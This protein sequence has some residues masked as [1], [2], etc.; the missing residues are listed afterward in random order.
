[1]RKCFASKEHKRTHSGGAATKSERGRPRPRVLRQE[2]NTRTRASALRWQE[3]F[4][5]SLQTILVQSVERPNASCLLHEIIPSSG[6]RPNCDAYLRAS[7]S[8]ATRRGRNRFV[9]FS[10]FAGVVSRRRRTADCLARAGAIVPLH[11][12]MEHSF[13]PHRAP[14]GLIEPL[15]NLNCLGFGHALR[16]E[17]NAILMRVPHAVT[18]R[19][20]GWP[21]DI[22]ILHSSLCSGNLSLIR[23]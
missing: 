16:T 7:F 3:M 8:L 13:V 14:I 10:A 4:P 20:A 5:H 18:I 17:H 12:E 19:V 21:N 6:L 2:T 23:C 22:A 9:P 15:R 1:M 11:A